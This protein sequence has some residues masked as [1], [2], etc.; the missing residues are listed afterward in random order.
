MET[1]QA[2]AFRD[3]LERWLEGRP[4]SALPP[5]RLH[6]LRKFV[7]RNRLAVAASAAAA[8]ALVAVSVV[9]VLQAQRATRS[10]AEAQA[11]AAKANATKD[12]LLSTYASADPT[13]RGGRDATAKELLIEAEKQLN[14]KLKGQPELQ[15]EVLG[16]VWLLWNRLGEVER[17]QV[18][19]DRRTEVLLGTGD[20]MGAVASTLSSAETAIRRRAFD[21][22]EQRIA[23]VESLIGGDKMP[24]ELRARVAYAKGALAGERGDPVGALKSLDLAVRESR[25]AG[26]KRLLFMGLVSRIF[27]QRLSADPSALR[28]DIAE[29][30]SL[31]P[32]L[33]ATPVE[34][35]GN[36]FQLTI[37]RYVMGEYASGW[38]EMQAIVA[39]A[40]NLYGRD[41]PG[42][43]NERTYWLRYCLRLGKTDLARAWLRDAARSGER[44][45]LQE[46]EKDPQWHLLV[47]RM[48]MSQRDWPAAED[49][50][51]AAARLLDSTERRGD[52]GFELNSWGEQLALHRAELALRRGRSTEVRGLLSS[53]DA[54]GVGGLVDNDYARW[55]ALGLAALA[56]RLPVQALDDLRRAENSAVTLLGAAH[57]DVALIRVDVA[58]AGAIEGS[59]MTDA[60]MVTLLQIAAP[61]LSRAF[62]PSHPAVEL[63]ADLGPATGRVD[64]AQFPV[65]RRRL[66]AV[67]FTVIFM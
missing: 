9:A 53:A 37:A 11:E 47:A 57:P 48:Y 56:Q 55:W 1:A 52:D 33:D 64:S 26:D 40:D 22:V 5:S 67:P 10:A 4:V 25:Q 44:S 15:A 23:R 21:D 39:A 51:G 20:R 46:Y 3:D 32:T 14:A 31:L 62:P 27:V 45:V 42:S 29:A 30:E 34:A 49:H 54:S 66:V 60:E 35:L 36:R 41:N 16:T 6:A 19:A 43:F 13:T 24:L 12:F 63:T 59:G 61:V 28:R 50:L 38:P 7:A 2:A 8:L 58:R 18:A 17:A 65:V